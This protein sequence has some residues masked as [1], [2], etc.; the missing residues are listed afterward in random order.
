MFKVE[1]S[2]KIDIDE[3]GLKQLIIDEIARQNPTIAVDDINFTQR[4]SPTQIEVAVTGHV[5]EGKQVAVSD[6]GATKD[7][8]EPVLDE[9]AEEEESLD[10]AGQLLAD[11]AEDDVDS[12]LADEEEPEEEEDPFE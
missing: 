4:R 5:E 12:L 6:K 10:A 7:V 8:A 2:V 9:E 1:H 3:A 11:E